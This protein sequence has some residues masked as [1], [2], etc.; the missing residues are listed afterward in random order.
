MHL[1]ITGDPLS[2]SVDVSVPIDL[3]TLPIPPGGDPA[4]ATFALTRAIEVDGQKVFEIVDKME[5]AGG[6]LTTA[7]PPFLGPSTAGDDPTTFMAY[8][9][10]GGRSVTS[11]RVVAVAGGSGGNGSE[12]RVPG[13]VVYVDSLCRR[14]ALRPV[15]RRP[16]AMD[17]MSAWRTTKGSSDC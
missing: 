2:E 9:V 13:A 1:D 8:T 11:G 16:W 17:G 15:R 10:N 5:F 12:V 4:D 7:S 6:K 3:A 14:S